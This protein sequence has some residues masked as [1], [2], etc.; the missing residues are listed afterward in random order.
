MVS[1]I[2]A[3]IARRGFLVGGSSLLGISLLPGR[4][5]SMDV[6]KDAILDR[7]KQSGIPGLAVGIAHRGRLL[8]ARGYG[9][10]DI[11]AGRPVTARTMFHIASITKTITAA[12]IMMLVD[13]GRIALD[14]PVAPHLDFKLAGPR[15]DEM[16]FRHLLMHTSGISD[17][18]YYE[19]DFRE[20]GR[21][22]D[23]ALDKFVRDYLAPGGEQYRPE[24][25]A[26]A[27]GELWDYSNVGYALL[28]LL[29]N[30]VTG[31]DMREFTRAH[32]FEPL[33]LK[34]ISW[35][36][37]GTPEA[38]RAIPY[39][40]TDGKYEPVELVGFPDWP[41][42]MIRASVADLTLLMASISNKGSGR[43]SHPIQPASI[44]E[45]FEIQKPAGLAEWLT[46]Q[47]LGW[48]QS[49]LEGIPRVNHWG[50]DPGVFTMAYV[51]PETEAVVVL[52]SNASTTAETRQA[53]TEIAALSLSVASAE[54][55]LA[56]SQ[57]RNG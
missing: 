5:H 51:D 23:M 12:A 37:K 46:G 22:S 6:P 4:A 20:P 1:D 49:R 8:S 28:G 34:D 52:L 17:A 11:A 50:G 54:H 13:Q 44:A 10:A 24:N 38:R 2:Q 19:V 53:L 9:M 26:R 3:P 35:T 45:M 33:G 47:G 40:M 15:S 7:M 55:A 32:L 30:R 43:G 42:G 56:G 39:D 27:P 41:A 36:I 29:A 21:D 31:Q 25:L 57:T 48:Q 16:S 18:H 14:E